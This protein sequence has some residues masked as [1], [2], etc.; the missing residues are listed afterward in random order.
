[1]RDVV[2]IG[3]GPSG[4]HAAFLLAQAGLNVVLFEAQ[5]R[6]GEK[7]I[8]SG[9]VG[10]E[11]FARFDLPTQPILSE[12][13]CIQAISPGGKKLEHR[14]E[15]PLA[16]VIDKGPFNRALAQRATNAGAELQLGCW[17]NSLEVEKHSVGIRYRT[18]DGTPVTLQSQ[19]AIITTGVNGSLNQPLGLAHPRQF[20]RAVQAEMAL[21]PNGHGN[22]TRVFV[23]QGVAPGAFG[24]EIPL[25]N[26]RWRVGLMTEHNPDPFFAKLVQ[27]IAPNTDLS[28]LR[29]DRKGIAQAAIGRCVVERIIAAGE[30]AGHIKT[31]TGG[32]IYYGLLSAELAADVVIRAFQTKNFSARTLGEFERYWRSTFGSELVVGYFARKLASH[33]TDG[34]ID[35]FFDAANASDLLVRLNGRLK[36]DWHHRALL[37]TLRALMTLPGGLGAR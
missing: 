13:R 37:A 4:S 3:A 29:V 28:T 22:A 10:D 1:M 26:N 33:F 12:I 23:G 11:A 16:Q 21:P 34:Q 8:C 15:A 9:V 35:R 36:F 31:T 14:T 17:V 6:V 27:R 30:A 19:V 25:G 2:V 32:G 5:S 20:L 18:P 7:A 24:W